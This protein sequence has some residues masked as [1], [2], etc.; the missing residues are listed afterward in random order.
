MLTSANADQGEPCS[1][2]AVPYTLAYPSTLTPAA[3]ASSSAPPR[4]AAHAPAERPWARQGHGGRAARRTLSAGGAGSQALRTRGCLLSAPARARPRAPRPPAAPR[5]SCLCGPRRAAAAGR[6]AARAAARPSSRARPGRRRS[7]G[8]RARGGPGGARARPRPRPP[9]RPRARRP[10]R[11]ALPRRAPAAA[12]LS[13]AR[14]RS[15][16][17][18]A[19]L[20]PAS[21][22]GAPRRSRCTRA[23][24]GRVRAPALGCAGGGAAPRASSA[25]RAGAR[26]AALARGGPGAAGPGARCGPGPHG[27]GA[28]R[29]AGRARA[30]RWASQAHAALRAAVAAARAPARTWL[31]GAG[32]RD[33]DGGRQRCTGWLG[34][35]NCMR[36]SPCELCIHLQVGSAPAV[37]RAWWQCTCG[38]RCSRSRCSWPRALD[39]AAGCGTLQAT[40]ASA[41]SASAPPCAAPARRP[42]AA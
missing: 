30:R 29:D 41:S 28:A 33:V 23:S 19:S 22:P 24:S 8:P 31:A 17:G 38:S 1:P 20:Q 6:A 11:A 16:T 40:S 18:S 10:A 32:V 3:R 15:P 34:P 25:G 2:A 13:A 9:R 27:P 7:P 5:A 35:V 39:G 42:T 12:A 37:S 26:A 21:A 14:S 4:A 36:S